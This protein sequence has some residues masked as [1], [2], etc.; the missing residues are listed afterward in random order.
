ML[1]RHGFMLF[2]D[3]TVLGAGLI[4]AF[5]NAALGL[6]FRSGSLTSPPPFLPILGRARSR[7]RLPGFFGGSP[8]SSEVG[9]SLSASGRPLGGSFWLLLWL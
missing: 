3:W 4:S 1:L 5:A 2:T 6:L 9:R 7:H 8:L